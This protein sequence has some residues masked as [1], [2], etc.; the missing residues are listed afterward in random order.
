LFGFATSGP[1][2]T[3]EALRI[4]LAGAADAIRASDVAV[5]AH[6]VVDVQGRVRDPERLRGGGDVDDPLRGS[7]TEVVDV[8]AAQRRERQ[9]LDGAGDVGGARRRGDLRRSGGDSGR[10][11]GA[12]KK[13]TTSRSHTVKTSSMDERR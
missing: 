5:P 6:D 10:P 11:G 9:P 8:P 2:S 12:E 1:Y 13:C 3:A 7:D 4:A